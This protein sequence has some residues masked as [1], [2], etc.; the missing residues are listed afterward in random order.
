MSVATART[1]LVLLAAA[2]LATGCG[3][4]ES[5]AEGAAKPPPSPAVN[6][7]A[8]TKQVCAAV[9][10]AI[11]DGSKKI[12]EDST[13][14]IEGKMTEAERNK[15]LQASF[16]SMAAKIREQAPKTVDPTIKSLVE[17]TANEL[18][19]GAKA[20]DATKFTSEQ[21]VNIATRIDEKCK[22]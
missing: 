19:A 8:N 13:K 7:A 16:A 9:T 10:Q 2:V 1:A 14:A 12:T 3:T 4:E 21:F 22:P 5:D 17:Q 15:Q 6:A 11:I 20:P 18:D